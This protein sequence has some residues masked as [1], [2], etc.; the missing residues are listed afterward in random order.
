MVMRAEA[1]AYT[2]PYADDNDDVT[3]HPLMVSRVLLL[4]NFPRYD[5]VLYRMPFGIWKLPGTKFYV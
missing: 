4:E 5:N 1:H 2:A 3:L